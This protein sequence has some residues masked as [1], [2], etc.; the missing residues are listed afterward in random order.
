MTLEG[1]LNKWT[2]HFHGWQYRYFVLD[3]NNGLLS[4]YLFK[5][6]IHKGEIRGC[7]RLNEAF[8]GYDK[9]DDIL[10]TITVGDETYHLQASNLSEKEKWVSHIE[11]AIILSH[12]KFSQRRP[13]DA[14]FEKSKLSE[15]DIIIS[16]DKFDSTV[17]ELDAYLQLLIEQQ[18]N[19]ESKYKAKH[20]D[21]DK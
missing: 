21:D 15:E 2:N 14:S 13:S 3:M 8:V 11:K 12:T 6:H 9:D 18:K 1:P 20:S 16:V 4:Y 10:F 17:T 5:E 19:L 7:I